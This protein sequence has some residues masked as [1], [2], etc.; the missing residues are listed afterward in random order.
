MHILP[1]F[2][3]MPVAAFM[4]HP[5]FTVALIFS[6]RCIR[7]AITLKILDT[8]HKFRRGILRQIVGNTL[9]DQANFEAALHNQQFMMCDGF[10]M[11]PKMHDT[12]PYFPYY[13]LALT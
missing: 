3:M 6:L 2:L 4:V 9:Q 7:T 5:G 12:P 10:K 8:I 13:M 1:I 11:F